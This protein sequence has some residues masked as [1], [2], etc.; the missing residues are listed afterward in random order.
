MVTVPAATPVTTP[1]ELTEAIDVLLLLQV[2]PDVESV[3]VMLPPV[4]TVEG[5]LI[6]L[7]VAVLLTVMV[8]VTLTGPQLAVTV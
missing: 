8:L 3:S 2:P 5:P 7:T 6:A 1:V 4:H